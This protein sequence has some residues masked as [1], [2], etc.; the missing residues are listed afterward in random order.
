MFGPLAKA[1]DAG[2]VSGA[3]VFHVALAFA[4]PTNT[5]AVAGRT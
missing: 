2:Y 4:A 5:V 3:L 1:P